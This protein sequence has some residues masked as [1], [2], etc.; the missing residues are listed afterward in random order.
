MA[1]QSPRLRFGT[2]EIDCST[3][4]LRKAGLKIRMEDQP[5]LILSL[6]ASRQGELVTR[7][8]LKE[9]IWSHDTYVDFD[10]SLNRAVNKV[11]AA[12]GDSAA[13]PLFIETV[14]R[15]G[16]RFLA[17]VTEIEDA[18]Q[19]LEPPRQVRAAP[20]YYTAAAVSLV[21]LT[22]GAL[23]LRPSKPD[24]PEWKAVPVTTYMGVERHPSLSPDGNHVAF[25]WN[26]PDRSNFDI[27]RKEIGSPDPVR[28]TGNAA[29]EFGPAWSPDGNTIAFLRRVHPNRAEVLTMP[30]GG[31][32]EQRITEIAFEEVLNN[33][34]FR[35]L[36]WS[37]DG[38][39]LTMADSVP[40]E[41]SFGLIRVSLDSGA[42]THL[43]RPPKGIP[44]DMSPTLSPDGRTL[45]FVRLK[46]HSAGEI[47]V[48]SLSADGLPVGEVRQV[49]DHHRWAANPVWNS[50]GD[51]LYYVFGEHPKSD[52]SLMRV[53]VSGAAKPERAW[54]PGDTITEFALARHLVFVREMDDY[55]IW[56]SENP[57]RGGKP[58][59][60][61][62]FL[63]G[64][65]DDLQP[66]YSPDGRML[67]F[68]SSRSG[69][70]EVWIAGADGAQPRQL[71]NFGGPLIGLA[72]W[73]PDGRYLT[74]HARPDGQADVYT[75][76]VTGGTPKRLTSHA[77]DDTMPGFS[78]DGRTIYFGSKRTGRHEVWKIP[79]EGGEAVQVNGTLGTM[80]RESKDG[81]VIYY[82]K[83]ST[84]IWE[85]PV[86]G[87][88]EKL[89]VGPINAIWAYFP[90]EDGIY[91]LAPQRPDGLTPI[92]FF[93][94]ATGRRSTVTFVRG[95]SQFG[96]TLTPDRRHILFA[97]L[98][99]SGSD[100][101]LV[102][103]FR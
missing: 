51:R 25:S 102:P 67:A 55:N 29:E 79:A 60:A 92:D 58:A 61:R 73:S 54:P 8:E 48:Q 42:R 27:Y 34:R 19:P 97:Q 36:A 44:G 98:D 77:S 1:L 4:E 38:R 31:G 103:D 85:T 28:L 11:R 6:L 18:P 21:A 90:V 47:C 7:E 3:G 93:E 9:A 2:F 24:P 56:K 68:M 15:R 53:L 91:F 62:L 41:V 16:Y 17:P 63:G 32:I 80:P 88:P 5:F 12:I 59:E 83:G 20:T 35:Q 14:P 40:G 57:K 33:T 71:T 26:G 96:L 22:A 94:F 46:G 74:F 39:S 87:G 65:T 99:Q 82:T 52:L 95:I 30:A 86:R 89:V 72:T 23:Y 81:R 101:M 66:Q 37:P 45:A 13:T 64:T 43:T 50:A 69:S 10:R 78:S 70:R 100:L 76:A 49:T 84:G 75:M